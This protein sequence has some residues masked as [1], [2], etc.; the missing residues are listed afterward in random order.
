MAFENAHSLLEDILVSEK[1]LTVQQI[2]EIRA[3]SKKTGISMERAIIEGGYIAED[4]LLRALAKKMNTTFVSLSK[5]KIDSNVARLLPSSMAR[6]Y[7][8]IPLF[9]VE[10]RITVA[11]SNPL[12]LD[13]I[14]EIRLALKSDID[15]V[16]ALDSDIENAIR[17]YYR[18]VDLREERRDI[19]LEI[20]KDVFD[21]DVGGEVQ[22]EKLKKEASGENI[23]STVSNVI[24]QAFEDRASDIHFEPS[25]ENL[26]VRVRIDGIM[27]KL[28]VLPK[29]TH[30]GIIS[31]IKIMGGMDIAE[32]RMAQ[33]GRVRVKLGADDMDLRIATYPTMFGEAAAIR[34]LTKRDIITMDQLGFLPDDLKSINEMITRPHGIFLVTGPTGSGKTTTLYAALININSEDKHILSIEDP[35]EHEIPNV[36]QQQVNVKAGVTFASALR[37]MLRQDPDIIMVGEI[38]DFETSEIAIRAAMTG[39]LVLS[40]LH[41]N[42]AVGAISRLLD[43]NIEPFLISSTLNGVAAQRLVRRICPKCKKEKSPDPKQ[44]KKLG[45]KVEMEKVFYGSG[46]KFCRSTGYYGRVGIFEVIKVND[47]IKTMIQEKKSEVAIK[48]EL[49]GG[50][51]KNMLDDAV[52]KVRLG[53]TTVEEVL[54][55]IEET[56]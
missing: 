5:F 9:K 29:N 46:C 21:P 41:T 1:L 23:V 30:Q 14:D 15:A 40:T 42:D 34:L 19:K 11:T 2:A 8:A 48:E 27:E 13:A 6:R 24:L 17:E 25:R 38:R 35:V 16:F 36:D 49:L 31:R 55:I 45:K 53:Y 39:H 4:V 52:E 26:K 28:T 56:I 44:L 47:A 37:S 54:R 20:V 3:S 18:G 50:G 10:N 7:R 12:N 32:R 33:D 51:F 43:L 22:A